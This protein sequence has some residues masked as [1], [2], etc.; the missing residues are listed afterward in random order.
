MIVGGESGGPPERA[1]V[2]KYVYQRKDLV[3]YPPF[4]WEP[5]SNAVEWVRSLRNQCLAAGVPFFFKQ[6]GG[7][8]PKGGGRLLDGQEW[9]EMPQGQKGT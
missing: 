2:S 4:V 1:L 5:K 8:T 3:H 6:W 7:Q 9:S